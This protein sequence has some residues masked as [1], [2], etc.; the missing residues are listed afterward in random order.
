M[1]IDRSK[2]DEI[3]VATNDCERILWAYINDRLGCL[4][5]VEGGGKTI[6]H[7]IMMPNAIATARRSRLP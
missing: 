3:E 6:V 4:T 5:Y 1:A 2:Y 7:T